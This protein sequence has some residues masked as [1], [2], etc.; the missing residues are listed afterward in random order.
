[1]MKRVKFSKREIDV[2]RCVAYGASAKEVPDLVHPGPHGKV[3]ESCVA[4]AIERIKTKIG[5]QKSTEIAAY[6]FCNYRGADAS[7]CPTSIKSILM[8]GV[9]L[10]IIM[11]TLV[12][13]DFSFLRTSRVGSRITRTARARRIE[14]E[15]EIV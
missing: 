6:Y 2:M 15:P 4:H 5:V 8:A 10:V 13:S 7:D 3:S 12:S 9:M 1:M 11:P 14:F